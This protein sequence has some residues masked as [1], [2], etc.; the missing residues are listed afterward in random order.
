MESG[1][2]IRVLEE[3]VSAAGGHYIPLRNGD[4]AALS[5]DDARLIQLGYKQ[6]LSRSL[7]RGNSQLLDDVLNHINTN[8]ADHN[9]C[10]AD[11]RLDHDK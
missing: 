11:I 2:G 3:A 9:E 7:S 4:D 5:Y 8:W 6:E 1:N 10:W